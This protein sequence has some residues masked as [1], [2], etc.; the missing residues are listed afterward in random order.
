MSLKDVNCNL[1]KVLHMR[2]KSTV[3]VLLWFL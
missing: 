1:L 2:G 3:W